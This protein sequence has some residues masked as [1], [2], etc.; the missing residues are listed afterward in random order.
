VRRSEGQKIGKRKE[1]SAS[2]LEVRP[3]AVG[4]LRLEAI[5]QEGEKKTNLLIF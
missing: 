4:G 3:A 2:R 5:K 1:V